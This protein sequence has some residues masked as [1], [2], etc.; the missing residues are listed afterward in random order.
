MENQYGLKKGGHGDRLNKILAHF[1]MHQNE[2]IVKKIVEIRN[3]LFHEGLWGT[4]HPMSSEDDK[5]YHSMRYLH[6]IVKR[7]LLRIIGIESPFIKSNWES[8]LSNYAWK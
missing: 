4:K 3:D 5:E 8:F 2:V 6:E 7:C 1:K